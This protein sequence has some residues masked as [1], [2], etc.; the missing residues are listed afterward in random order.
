M[1]YIIMIK[2]TPS[3]YAIIPANVRYDNKLKANSKLLYGEITALSNKKGYCYASNN[4][5][6]ELYGVSKET[7]SRWIK[8]LIDRGYLKSTLIYKDGSKEIINRYLQI[9]QEG[10]DENVK[11]P[12]DEKINTPIDENVKGNNTSNNNTSNNNNNNNKFVD[13]V[14]FVGR[15]KEIE[16]LFNLFVKEAKEGLHD[17]SVESMYMRLKIR[18]GS[19]THLLE[20]FKRQLII[21]DVLHKNTLQFRKHFSNWLN[22]Q[23]SKGKL[24]DYKNKNKGAL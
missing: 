1:F 3:Y 18:K 9:N 5:F 12:I 24:T 14:S 2:E 6:A 13:D 23:D 4:Y 10:I 16:N 15:E 8:E 19:L 22:V 20:D 11:T 7:I 21:D 17:L